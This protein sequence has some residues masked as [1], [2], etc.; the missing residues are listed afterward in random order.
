[1]SDDP[2]DY[3]YDVTVTWRRSDGSTVDLPATICEDGE[4]GPA[5][6]AGVFEAAIE[7]NL[8]D[9]PDDLDEGSVPV[10]LVFSDAPEVSKPLTRLGGPFAGPFG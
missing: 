3:G 7:A 1:M 10:R 5:K 9:F 2:V 6:R 8:S 4:D